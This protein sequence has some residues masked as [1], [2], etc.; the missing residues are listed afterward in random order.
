MRLAVLTIAAVLAT[1]PAWGQNT[2]T[3][4]LRPIPDTNIGGTITFAWD[5]TAQDVIPGLITKAYVDTLD[6][7]PIA[8]TCNLA[9]CSSTS[10]LAGLATPGRHTIILTV[11]D[12]ATGTEGPPSNAVVT[13]TITGTC[14]Y[15]APAGALEQR[16]IGS[17]LQG[18][19]PFNKTP[20]DN[21]AAA[22]LTLL[23]LNG[24]RMEWQLSID[25]RQPGLF[26]AGSCYGTPQ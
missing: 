2:L 10:V 14:P 5:R 20:G 4:A 13:T 23:R 7:V 8:V 21:Y 24:W 11:S 17:S 15:Q 3:R 16:A 26:T 6:G 19:I 18:F 9:V 12:P 25:P 1:V 22:R